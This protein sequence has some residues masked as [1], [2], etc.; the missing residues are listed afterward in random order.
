MSRLRRTAARRAACWIGGLSAAV[1]LIS[2]DR[3]APLQN[4]APAGSRP[5][6]GA[7]GE[8]LAAAEIERAP[9]GKRRVFT[10][11][12]AGDWYSAG[13][14]ELAGEI[15]GY[16]AA[17]P[18]RKIEKLC[19]LVLPHAGY[20]WSGATAAHGVRQLQ[21]RA[22]D[23][24][25]VIGPSHRVPMESIASVP[26]FTHYATPL[27]EVALDRKFIAELREHAEFQE[28]PFVHESEHSVGI[29]LPLLQRVLNDFQLVPIVV[30]DL[31]RATVRKLGRILGGLV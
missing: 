22:I 16:L 15:D 9:S 14:R 17:A 20:R 21:D 7:Q 10:S 2:C 6:G 25:V 11:P 30:G 24:V 27:G 19:G 23:R 5:P 26:G 3:A 4:A 18:D 13:R 8:P 12:L 28:I 29:Q 1:L 31:D